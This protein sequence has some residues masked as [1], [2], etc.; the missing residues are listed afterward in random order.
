M[1]LQLRDTLHWCESGGR[2]VFLD[3]EADR[4]FCLSAPA[5]EAFLRLAAGRAQPK[6]TEDLQALI[7]RGMLVETLVEG[8]IK[9]PPSIEDPTGDFLGGPFG[10]LRALSMLRT[11]SSELC[12]A[13]ALRTRPFHQVLE[14]VQRYRARRIRQGR[15]PHGRHLEPTQEA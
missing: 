7:A 6:D 13:W 11:I 3:V 15:S 14:D 2:V 1:P 12:W 5:S 8:G 10:D 9:V 4:Y